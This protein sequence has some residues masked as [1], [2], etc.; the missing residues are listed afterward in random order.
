MSHRRPPTV[1]LRMPRHPVALAL[2]REVGFPSP[3]Q[4]QPLHTTF[5]TTAQHVR[6][7]FGDDTPFLLDGGPCEV[8]L[9]ST[10]IAV[11]PMA[12]KSC[13]PAWRL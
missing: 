1:G 2:L 5:P 6:E 11:T 8:G 12:W 3:P 9:E 10:V 4:R 13:A 7:A